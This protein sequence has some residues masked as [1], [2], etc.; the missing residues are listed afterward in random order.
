MVLSFSRMLFVRFTTS[1]KLAELIR[2]HLEAFAFFGGW[3]EQILFDNMKQVR[4]GPE[5]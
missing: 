5:Q 2:C 4:L 3:P 1:M